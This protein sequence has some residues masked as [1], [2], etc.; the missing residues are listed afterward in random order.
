MR[1]MRYGRPNMTDLP[2]E[3]GRAIFKQILNTPRPDDEKLEAE[4]RE[5]EKWMVKVR[6]CEDGE[7]NLRRKD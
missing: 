7:K 1:S 6:E 2:T 5:L 4:V 3:L